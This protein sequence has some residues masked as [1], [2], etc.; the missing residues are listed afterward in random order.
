MITGIV[1]KHEA[2]VRV[3]V[4]GPLG[5]EVDAIVDTGYTS[6]LTLPPAVVGALGLHW[7]SLGGG[8]LADGSRC[9]FDVYKACIEWDG[10]G[11]IVTSWSTNW[12]ALRNWAW[13]SCVVMRFT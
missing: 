8:V 7:H 9:T 5:R 12:M 2:H 3:T 13:H 6:L 1:Q 11:A 10:M 4:I